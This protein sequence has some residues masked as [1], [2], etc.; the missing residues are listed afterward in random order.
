MH[1]SAVMS[2]TAAHPGA[3]RKAR[4]A[5]RGSGPG[6]ELPP[7]RTRHAVPSS[8]PGAVSGIMSDCELS[9]SGCGFLQLQS[10]AWNRDIFVVA[11]FFLDDHVTTPIRCPARLLFASI[12]SHLDPSHGAA[13]GTSEVP[14]MV[15]ARGMDCRVLCAGVF[16]YEPVG[17]GSPARRDR[18]TIRK[19]LSSSTGS[20]KRSIASGPACCSPTAAS[21]PA[22][23]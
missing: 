16:D 4:P 12:Q 11:G 9:R 10:T 7:H 20:T 23:N 19:G 21:R 18:L 3:T 6:A 2:D 22:S 8:A 5:R 17:W 14:E 15:A 13:P 1:A